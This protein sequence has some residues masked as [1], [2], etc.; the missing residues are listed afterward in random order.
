[1]QI[2]LISDTHIPLAAEKLPDEVFRAFSKVNLIL[3]AGD[4]YKKSILDELE[5]LANLKVGRIITGKNGV[6]FPNRTLLSSGMNT[7][8]IQKLPKESCSSIPEVRHSST[9]K[10]DWELS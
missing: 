6:N 2:G 10:R 7:G 5:K 8:L 3:H 1:M 9:T 4:F